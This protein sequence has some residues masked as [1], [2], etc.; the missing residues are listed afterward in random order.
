MSLRNIVHVAAGQYHS[1]AVDDK[2]QVFAWGLNT[3]RQLGVDAKRGGG[4]DMIISP[5]QVDALHP[6]RHGGAKVMSIQGGEHHSLFLF[7]NGEVW[8]CGRADADQIGLNDDHPARE[9]M[10]ERREEIKAEK[11]L[12]VD[13][14]EKELK[15]AKGEE[16]VAEKERSVAAAQASFAAALDEFVPEPVRVS[17]SRGRL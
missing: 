2:G 13:Q 16:E 9:G 1:F 10:K 14:A 6:D 4:E 3:F 11:K 17:T 5:T 15:E 8:A 7:D 12:K